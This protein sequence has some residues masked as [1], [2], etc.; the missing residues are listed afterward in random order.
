LDA[1]IRQLHLFSPLVQI[2]RDRQFLD[3]LVR[4]AGFAFAHS[5]KLQRTSLAGIEQRLISLNPQSVLDRGYAIVSMPDGQLVR[6]TTQVR[7]GD[8][9]DVRVSDGTFGVRV[10]GMENEAK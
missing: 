10:D 9:L 7:K 5:L 6:R 8:E 4:R 3:S 2:R 1:Q